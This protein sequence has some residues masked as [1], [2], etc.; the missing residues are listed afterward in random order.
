MQAADLVLLDTCVLMNNPDIIIRVNEKGGTVFITNTVLDE[1]DY[2][3]AGEEEPN[4][5]ARTFLKEIQE[6][7]IKRLAN[8][9]ALTALSG[10][11]LSYSAYKDVK[12]NIIHRTVFRPSSNNDSKIIEIADAYSLILISADRGMVV[13]ATA[14]GINSYYWHGL[15]IQRFPT[16]RKGRIFSH[17]SGAAVKR[18]PITPFRLSTEPIPQKADALTTSGLPTDGDQVVTPNGKVVVLRKSIAAGGEGHIF[19]TDESSVVCKIYKKESLTE[20]KRDKIKLMLTRQVDIRGI[21]W[22][23]D[24]VMNKSGDFV[25][26]VM[27]KAHGVP[28]QPTI[29]VKP[30][31]EKC[32]PNW[33]RRDLAVVCLKFLEYMQTLHAANIL[34]GD[35]NPLNI[36]INKDSDDVWFVDT[37]SFQIENYPCPV[38]T[39][40]FTAPEIQ[41]Q[42][43]T[44]FLRTKEHELFAVAT[45]LFMILLPGKPPYSQQGGGTPGEN[46]R[47]MRFPYPFHNDE[48]NVQHRGENLP[49][50]PYRF[51]WSHLSWGLKEAFHETFRN[52]K[53]VSLE[54]W[55]DLLGK[56]KFSIESQYLSDKLFPIEAKV[57]D[58][59]EASCGKCGSV[60]TLQKQQAEYLESHGKRP[61]CSK[62]V[63]QNTLERLA[64]QAQDARQAKIDGAQSPRPNRPSVGK[65]H[66]PPRATG[67][68]PQTPAPPSSDTGA[69][70]GGA[71]FVGLTAAGYAFGGPLGGLGVAAVLGI[72]AAAAARGE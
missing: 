59:V 28:L 26:Y 3:K 27:P 10:D 43:Y 71:V 46:I 11:V 30:H 23:I 20:L 58:G 37:D 42:K 70:A 48:A 60:F 53:R 45:M 29:F 63:K 7:G 51:I 64:R 55:M 16:E 68:P 61:W 19:L 44:S 66:L 72:L 49:S 56:Y 21:A 39:V 54:R 65:L 31:F 33:T 12:V 15:D 36:L 1:L 32:L 69:W 34:V 4:R 2:N 50:G 57:I 5:N 62:C 52:N 35:I 25:G 41:G 17:H 40:N 24:Y 9:D 8:T 18:H 38:G 6:R 13:R 67:V 22:P 14:A 47:N